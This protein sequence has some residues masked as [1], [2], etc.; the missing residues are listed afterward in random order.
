MVLQLR[1]WPQRSDWVGKS[2]MPS[3]WSLTEELQSTCVVILLPSS[4]QKSAKPFGVG[5]GAT[6][7]RAALG[8]CGFGSGSLGGD[9]G[10]NSN[11]TSNNTSNNLSGDVRKKDKKKPPPGFNNVNGNKW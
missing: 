8:G 6:L 4:C 5:A 11:N 9:N 2:K 7:G 10:N 1:S 3:P